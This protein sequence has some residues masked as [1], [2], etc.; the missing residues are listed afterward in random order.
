MEKRQIV[1]GEHCVFLTSMKCMNFQIENQPIICI[2]HEALTLLGPT[3]GQIDH[4]LYGNKHN[5]Q[6]AGRILY[7]QCKY[8]LGRWHIK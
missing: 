6:Y 2:Q 8:Y 1:H 7:L 4:F 3:D 5:A